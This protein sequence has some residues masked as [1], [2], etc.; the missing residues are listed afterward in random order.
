MRLLEIK[1]LSKTHDSKQS[2]AVN[3]VSFSLEEG[4]TLSLVGESGSGKTTLLRLIAGLLE[5]DQGKVYLDGTWV[6]GPSRHLVPGHPDI[7][8]VFQ[9][10]E[11]SPNLTVRQNIARILQ[12]YEAEYRESRTETLI[13]LCRLEKVGQRYPR[14][15]SGGEKQRLALAR[16][17]A[18]EPRL[19]LMDEPFS[20]ID[21]SLKKHLKQ[22]LSEILEEL[23]LA[24]IIVTHDPEDALAMADLVAVM[25]QGRLLQVDTPRKVYHQPASDYVASLFGT[26]NFLD[27]KD[28]EQLFNRSFQSRICL[29]A[30]DIQITNEQVGVT[31]RVKRVRFMGAFQELLV[32]TGQLKLLVHHRGEALS[33]NS[34]VMLSIPRDKVISL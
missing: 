18:E 32:E 16:A 31:A 6:K 21:L 27:T 33:V 24:T 22:E 30:E 20:N 4:Q 11:L 19:L 10:Y 29:R 15:L 23:N 5:P 1:Q 25:R 9:H 8:V 2:P 7:K 14:A 13:R 17:I 34:Q 28:A 3:E 26:C 12:A